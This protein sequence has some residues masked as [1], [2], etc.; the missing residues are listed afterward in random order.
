MG[1]YLLSD[2]NSGENADNFSSSKNW[3]Q[4]MLFDELY[5]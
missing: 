1:F 2:Q 4:N 5:Y 3:A